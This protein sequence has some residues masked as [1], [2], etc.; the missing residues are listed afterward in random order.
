L[1][2]IVRCVS[3]GIGGSPGRVPIGHALSSQSVAFAHVFEP[4]L[5]SCHGS[6][7]HAA[8]LGRAAA[9]A[10]PERARSRRRP[11]ARRLPALRLYADASRAHVPDLRRHNVFAAAWIGVPTPR[12]R[13]AIAPAVPRAL[14][15]SR[16][17]ERAVIYPAKVPGCRRRRRGSA[18]FTF[19]RASLGP[20]YGIHTS[21]MM[22]F[23]ASAI[24]GR[25]S[26]IARRRP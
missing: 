8:R 5:R 7:P 22:S 23:P 18:G 24:I 10:L 16:S 9:R 17:R 21:S 4:R 6:T 19:L 11:G 20:L 12:V 2:I 1:P 26:A 15:N 25:K 14:R 13:R 3:R